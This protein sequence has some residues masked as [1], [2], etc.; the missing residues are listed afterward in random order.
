MLRQR[1][2]VEAGTRATGGENC[3]PGLGFGSQPIGGGSPL[4]KKEEKRAPKSNDQ[5]AKSNG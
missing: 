4:K 5:Y 2:K 1:E 3:D